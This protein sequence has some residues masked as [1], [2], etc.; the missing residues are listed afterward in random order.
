M[1]RGV[2]HLI[3]RYP[4]LGGSFEELEGFPERRMLLSPVQHDAAWQRQEI[5]RVARAEKTFGPG[6]GRS[7]GFA[8][9]SVKN[10]IN[11]KMNVQLNLYDVWKAFGR[12]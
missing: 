3:A 6:F 2:T 8:G 11:V 4:Q 9:Q 12:V 1:F 5:Q 7:A 10:T